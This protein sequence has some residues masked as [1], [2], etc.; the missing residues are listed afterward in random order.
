MSQLLIRALRRELLA[1]VAVV[2]AMSL[3]LGFASGSTSGFEPSAAPAHADGPRA[4]H[5]PCDT[6]GGAVGRTPRCDDGEE[7]P[8]AEEPGEE[9]PT[10]EEPGE[11]EPGD[12]GGC[13][14]GGAVDGGATL[15]EQLGGPGLDEDGP[16]SGP[17]HDE[18]DPQGGEAGPV[19]HELACG[20]AGLE[21]QLPG[22]DEPG[23]EES[24]ED[25]PG[26]EGSVEEQPGEVEPREDESGEGQSGEGESGEE[27]SG[28]EDGCLTGGPDEGD[29][30]SG[31]A[32]ELA[33]TVTTI[34]I[35]VPAGV[36]I[37]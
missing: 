5:P 7:E 21:S 9:G 20:A 10:G 29:P 11:G 36:T 30:V 22:E 31:A 8:G 14:D 27:A 26:E 3:S 24:G 2:A 16:V 33:C 18:A 34:G 13:A 28:G 19:L 1:L 37:H 4:Y 6:P 15:G 25:E 32:D 17:I 23:E 35:W 12:E